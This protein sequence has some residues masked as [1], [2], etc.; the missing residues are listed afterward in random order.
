MAHLKGQLSLL[1]EEWAHG[2]KITPAWLEFKALRKELK[3]FQ[4]AKP[5]KA[6][7]P[8]PDAESTEELQR[9]Q[10]ITPTVDASATT[11]SA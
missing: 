1:F 4:G 6:E 11:V 9:Q 8:K 3:Q 5:S 7:N 2:D 10:A